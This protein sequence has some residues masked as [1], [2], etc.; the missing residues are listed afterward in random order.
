MN[1]FTQLKTK[2]QFLSTNK[3][4]KLIKNGF[5]LALRDYKPLFLTHAVNFQN[6][7][8]QYN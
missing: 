7:V 8:L 1:T 4:K 3:N 6:S 5:M 2:T